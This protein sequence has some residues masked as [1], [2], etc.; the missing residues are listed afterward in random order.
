MQL[1]PSRVLCRIVLVRKDAIMPSIT[2]SRSRLGGAI[3]C[4]TQG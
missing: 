4:R 3:G 2:T 1:N